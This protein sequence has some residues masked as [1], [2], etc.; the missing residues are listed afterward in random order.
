M[1]TVDSTGSLKDA[2]A[3]P[4]ANHALFPRRPP[5]PDESQIAVAMDALMIV[6]KR[7]TSMGKRPF[8]ALLLAPDNTTILL[9]HQSLDHVN[10]A[11]SSLARLA[12]SHYQEPYLWRCTL[13]STWEPC[14]M[15]VAT[16]YWANIGRIVYAASEVDL[17][18][19]TGEGNEENM[20]MAMPC[21]E[22]LKGSQKD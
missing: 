22:V 15:C 21:R 17:A 1:A 18:K 12:S 8:T 10:H 6:Q 3:P 19:L 4:I 16:C 20:T 13:F 2:P 14:A 9:T 5:Q 11:E 7:A